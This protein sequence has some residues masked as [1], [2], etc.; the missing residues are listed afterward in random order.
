MIGVE[1][2]KKLY[3]R[4]AHFSVGAHGHFVGVAACDSSVRIFDDASG[5]ESL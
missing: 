5:M 4:V 2:V 1:C 3:A